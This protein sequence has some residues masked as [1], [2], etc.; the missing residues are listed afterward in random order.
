MLANVT[1]VAP[2]DADLA[3]IASAADLNVVETW[4]IADLPA[5]RPGPSPELLLLDLRALRELPGE[6]EAFKRRH[7]TTAV[8]LVAPKLEVGLLRDAMR[9][10]VSECVVMPVTPSE[11]RTAVMRVIDNDASVAAHA[12]VFAFVGAKGGAGATTVAAN[13][14][15]ALAAGPNPSV[16]FVDLHTQDLGDAAVY[17]GVEPR[18]SVIDAIENVRRLDGAF[19]R[20]LAARAACNVDVLAA[21]ATP[22]PHPPTAAA[23]HALLHWLVMQYR[24]VVIDMPRLSLDVLDAMEPVTV[25][26][27][28]VTQELAAVRR[29]TVIATLLRQRYGRDRVNVVL[30][31]YDAR[32]EIGRDDVERA[33][34]LRVDDVLPSDPGATLA[35]A[36]RGEPLVAEQRNRLA[37]ALVALARRL[38]GAFAQPSANGR[39]GRALAASAVNLH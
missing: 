11:L 24:F 37:R 34:G 20:G 36:N 28:V 8:I 39:P 13:V 22:P 19:L 23:V 14:A 3:R 33:I 26:S 15:A 6:L 38:D 32:A 10:G 21:P 30:N 4:T 17:F 35:A 29:G 18:F 31:R 9:M 7:P 5:T 1:L 25:A 16:V 27:V 2:A 12:K